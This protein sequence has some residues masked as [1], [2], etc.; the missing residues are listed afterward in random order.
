MIVDIKKIARKTQA[1]PKSSGPAGS[2]N[3]A[4]TQKKHMRAA[5]SV[6]I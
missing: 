2:K 5:Q 6:G 4:A 3:S 1:F